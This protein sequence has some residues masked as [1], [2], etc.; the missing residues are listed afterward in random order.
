MAEFNTNETTL[1][2]VVSQE[3]ELARRSASIAVGNS[4]NKVEGKIKKK[5]DTL[6]ILGLEDPETHDYDGNDIS[7]SN[8]ETT[9]NKIVIDTAKYIGKTLLDVDSDISEFNPM[10][11]LSKKVG[12]VI[13]KEHDKYIFKNI[14]KAYADGSKQIVDAE[15]LTSLTT[16]S[17]LADAQA[18]LLEADVP[19]DEETVIEVSPSFATKL[20]MAGIIHKTDNGEEFKNAYLGNFG[21]TKIMLTNNIFTDKGVQN[22]ILRSK[23]AYAFAQTINKVEVVKTENNFGKKLKALTLY[24]GKIIRPKEI[25][26]IKYTPGEETT[27]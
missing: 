18:K 20:L 22:I 15:G 5:G 26:V 4:W 11:E 2:E 6:N 12:Y 1:Q 16:L 13:G 10:Q 19:E 7:F 9:N 8:I 23:K 17:L 3:I 24:G 21:K 25:V 14:A 27:I